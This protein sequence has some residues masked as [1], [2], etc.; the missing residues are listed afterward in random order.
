MSEL[1]IYLTQ[2]ETLRFEEGDC[3]VQAR[4]V[5][6]G[7]DAKGTPTKRIKVDRILLEDVIEHVNS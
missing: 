7:G 1:D 4:W 2:E 6:A 5:Y 3:E